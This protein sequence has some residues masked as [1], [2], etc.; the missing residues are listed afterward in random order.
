[1][2]IA[3]CTVSIVLNFVLVWYARKLLQKLAFFSED[4]V[5]LNESLEAFSTHLTGLHA[6]ET[7]YGDQTL[8]NLIEH[9]KVIVEGVSQFKDLY[10]VGE[11]E[12]GQND[13]EEEE[14]KVE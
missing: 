10:M 5:D 6:Q 1:M 14:Q 9:S 13:A 2:I 11:F 4:I 7:Y 12:Q 8:Q 3:I